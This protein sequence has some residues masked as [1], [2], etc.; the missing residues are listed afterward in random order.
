M[1]KCK[2]ACWKYST[3]VLVSMSVA[4]LKRK[5]VLTVTR[6]REYEWRSQSL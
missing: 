6:E 1:Y 4:I 5:I 3:F 2:E